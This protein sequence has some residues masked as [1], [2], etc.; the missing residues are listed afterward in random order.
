MLA[1][2]LYYLYLRG[3][4]IWRP[5]VV[6]LAGGDGGVGSAGAALASATTRR[7]FGIFFRPCVRL[8]ACLCCV[9]LEIPVGLQR[10]VAVVRAPEKL[11]V[12]LPSLL[13]LL[14]ALALTLPRRLCFIRDLLVV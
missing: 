2:N 1:H 6:V 11:R 3:T 5:R 8:L 12:P 9:Y 13:L 10:R 7:R 14:L 4:L